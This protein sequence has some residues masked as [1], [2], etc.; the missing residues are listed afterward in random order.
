MWTIQHRSWQ[1]DQVME[2]AEELVTRGAWPA[3]VGLDRL[4][5]WTLTVE[6]EMNARP[7]TLIHNDVYPPNIGFPPDLSGEA[8]LIDWEMAGWGLAELDLAYLFMQ[9][10]SSSAHLDRAACLDFYWRAR[11]ALGDCIP[12]LDERCVVQRYADALWAIYEIAVAHFVATT[13]PFAPG[14]PPHAFWQ[15]MLPVLHGKLTM[16]ATLAA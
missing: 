14:S 12:P 1:R 16:L 5:D 7:V 8:V 10:F 9:P 4:V 6:A 2:M 11:A 3:I 13:R 15:A